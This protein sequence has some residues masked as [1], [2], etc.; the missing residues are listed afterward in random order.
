MKFKIKT[1]FIITTQIGSA[2]LKALDRFSLSSPDLIN[3]IK[4]PGQK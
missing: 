2:N 1:I 3:V 4:L